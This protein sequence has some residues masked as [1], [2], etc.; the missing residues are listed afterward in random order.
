MSTV[1]IR[2]D[3]E[4]LDADGRVRRVRGGAVSVPR[5]RRETSFLESLGARADEK[6]AIG[7]A[8]AALVQPG[9]SVFIDVGTATTALARALVARSE[10]ED[11]VLLTN[12]LPTALELE[13]AIP[14]YSVIVLGGTLRPLQHSLVDP[15]ASVLL[16][17]LHI[18]T[19]FIG[20]TGVTVARG[21]TNVNLPEAEVKRHVVGTADRTIVLADGSK[22]GAVSLAPVCPITDVD[23]L[24][25][26]V[27]AAADDLDELEA[28]GLAGDVVG[29]RGGI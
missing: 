26:S 19:A 20:C 14:R 5:R 8:A 7:A 29:S 1:T 11:I 25:T 28:A 23:L 12:A 24:V 6:E 21:I 17:R 16:E 3:L 13:E 27:S 15:L 18:D 22:I 2:S 4:A 9:E 10:L